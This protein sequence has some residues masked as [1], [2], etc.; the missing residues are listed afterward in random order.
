MNKIRPTVKLD[1]V[2]MYYHDKSSVNVGISKISLEFYK[3]EFVAVTGE[4]GSGKT[5]L[6]NVIGASLGYHD[7]EVYYDGET[8]SHFDDEERE[9]FRRERI[10]YVC[11]NYN[12][13]DS[14]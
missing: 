10:G 13:I 8:S 4:S 1:N 7:G 5:S 9:T 2:S 3:G 12:L 14:Y 11:Q 6:L